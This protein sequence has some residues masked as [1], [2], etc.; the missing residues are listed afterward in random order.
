MNI[1]S[2]DK[3]IA[4]LTLFSG[5]LVSS[6]AIYY[7]VVGLT[8]IFAAATVPIVIMGTALELSKLSATIWLKQNWCYAPKLIKTYLIIAISVLMLV[9][10]MGIFG[11]LSKAHL[12]QSL[13]PS[14]LV[15]RIQIID[16]QIS[17]EKQHI[18][19]ARKSLQYLD[20]ASTQVM[21]RTTT[22]SGAKRAIQLR[23]SQKAER[24][25]LA[26]VI[27][28]H[29]ARIS[30]LTV[31]RSSLS[32]KVKGFE[33]EV[34]PIKYLASFFYNDAS[35]ETL[36]KAVTWVILILILVFDPLAVALLLAAQTSFQN[37]RNIKSEL[38]DQIPVLKKDPEVIE[39]DSILKSHPYLLKP[40]VHF[41]NIKPIVAIVEDGIQSAKSIAKSYL[42][43]SEILNRS[44]DSLFVQN[45]EQGESSL[46]SK[47]VSTSTSITRE[48]YIKTI[49]DRID[50]VK[51]K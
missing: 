11:F 21:D 33:A 19:D 10:S 20:T 30:E 3:A 37:I 12:D 45:E 22:E 48:E 41:S 51:G 46:W 9:T 50:N 38:P 49:Q 23:N 1:H 34:G 42:T 28:K 8:A 25:V 36:E 15:S 43:P 27:Q 7:S 26:D 32:S 5:L 13:L 40:F 47:T 35:Q 16:D 14:D 39:A 4:Y 24:A 31:E 29:Q 6:V 17:V 18:E 2:N 44:N